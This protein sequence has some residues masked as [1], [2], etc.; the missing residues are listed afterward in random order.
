MT[1][2]AGLV[3][4]QEGVVW[5]G[6]DSA[7]TQEDGRLTLRS[8]PKVFVVGPLLIGGTTSFRMLQLL[9]FHLVVPEYTPSHDDDPYRFLVT[10]V[11]DAVR[12][13][14]KTGGFAARRDEQE[15]GG[16]FLVGFAG[17]LYCIQDDYQV[18]EA[19]E[20]YDA[21]GSGDELALGSLHTTAN[22]WVCFRGEDR[23]KMALE[24][25]QAHSAFV[26]EPFLIKW[27]PKS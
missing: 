25:A 16:S 5:I 8:D 10:K 15:E 20:G 17:H 9:R 13:C 4:K 19:A 24:A 23:V 3:D 1:V 6:A 22:P 18:R 7:G 11:V 2:I 12:D 26:R 14:L 27:L 21:I